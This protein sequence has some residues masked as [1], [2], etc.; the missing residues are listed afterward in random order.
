MTGVQC[1]DAKDEL[2][3]KRIA[4]TDQA[5]SLSVSAVAE[6]ITLTY[7]NPPHTTPKQDPDQGEAYH[8]TGEEAKCT[9][10]R[11]RGKSEKAGST[12]GS[13]VSSLTITAT[14]SI[15]PTLSNVL[16]VSQTEP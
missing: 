1:V 6:T 7:P 2:E 10:S 9:A 16:S 5:V 8:S 12:A 11:K 14:A 4:A 3:V 13:T 15:A